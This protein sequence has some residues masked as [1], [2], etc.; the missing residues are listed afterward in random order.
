MEVLLYY[1]NVT[2]FVNRMTRKVSLHRDWVIK[3]H[4]RRIKILN[5]LSFQLHPSPGEPLLMLVNLRTVNGC[6]D[7]CDPAK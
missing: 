1:G 5:Q 3:T 6:L 2:R 7:L 4:L